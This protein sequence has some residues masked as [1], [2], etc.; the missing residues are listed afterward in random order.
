MR[1]ARLLSQIQCR[2]IDDEE[3]SQNNFTISGAKSRKNK[4]AFISGNLV[5]LQKCYYLRQLKFPFYRWTRNWLKT[6]RFI[7]QKTTG[8]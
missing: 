1:E 8:D 5:N 6:R 7:F 2:R 3:L 4:M